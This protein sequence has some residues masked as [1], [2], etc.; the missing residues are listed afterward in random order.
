MHVLRLPGFALLLIMLVC[1]SGAGAVASLPKAVMIH[2][3]SGS[4]RVTTYRTTVGE[5][6]VDLGITPALE[7]RVTPSVSTRLTAGMRIEYLRAFPVIL[8][9]DGR[10]RTV[11]T[12]AATVDEFL[13]ARPAG[14]VVRPR[15]R[16]YPSPYDGLWPGATVRVVRLETKITSEPDRVPYAQVSRPDATLPRGL[17]RVIQAGRPGTRVRQIATTTADGI[18]IERRVVGMIVTN[19]PQDRIVQ[20]GTRRVWA[21]RGP[22]AG[23][24]II[25]MEATAYAPWDGP[26]TNDITSIGMKAG[27]GVVAIDPTVIPYRSELFIEG[28]GRA[29][30]GDTGGAIVGHRIDLGY[31]TIREALNFG[32]RVVKVYIISTPG[33]R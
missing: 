4:H 15:D 6:F 5:V 25:M 26:G 24:E 14:V 27:Y 20:I 33:Q 10:R 12:V 30:A 32:R 17:T 18:V 19:P 8:V 2:S 16:V 3:S 29:I 11:M 28:Y 31:N 23:K 1:S 21:S 9:V 7:D 22:Y 13:A